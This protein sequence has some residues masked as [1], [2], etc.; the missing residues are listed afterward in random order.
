[1]LAEFSKQCELPVVLLRQENGGPGKARNSGIRCSKGEYVWLVDCDDDIDIAAIAEFHRLRPEGFD[2]I[3]FDMLNVSPSN[4]MG[5]DFGRHRNSPELRPRL[6][7]GYGAL[8][9]KITRR[10]LFI[11]NDVWYPDHCFYEDNALSLIW[12][13]YVHT[14]YKSELTAYIHLMDFASV[15]RQRVTVRY[16]DRLRTA[17]WGYSI[18]RKLATT[19]EDVAAA[20]NRFIDLYLTK[21]TAQIFGMSYPDTGFFSSLKSR[22]YAE[23]ASK[24]V[25]HF[26][27]LWYLRSWLQSAR[28]HRHFREI[29][30]DIDLVAHPLGRTKN[31][32]L[33]SRIR[34]RAVWFTSFVLPS[35]LRYFRQLSERAWPSRE[36]YGSW[37][38]PRM[39]NTASTLIGN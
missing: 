39:P 27:S 8:C 23:A 6:L 20:E 18:A 22:R 19:P 7:G 31:L 36:M 9:T 26:G 38:E 29:T 10:E 34:L 14:F 25:K 35:Q 24:M 28:V 3:D 5:L 4:T 21:T 32:D 30:R 37:I 33:K 16:F 17:A 11:K 1:M 15:T 12:P 13:F 2:F